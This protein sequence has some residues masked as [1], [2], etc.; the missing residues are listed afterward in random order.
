MTMYLAAV[1]RWE[2][3]TVA[4]EPERV[5]RKGL[6]VIK[7]LEASPPLEVGFERAV[8]S[9]RNALETQNMWLCHPLIV[10]FGVS[11]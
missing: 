6:Q 1:P 4:W 5:N 3:E 2:P 11:H 8:L 9:F 7:S 10:G